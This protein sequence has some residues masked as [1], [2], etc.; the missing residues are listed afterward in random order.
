MENICYTKVLWKFTTLSWSHKRKL[1]AM[2]CRNCLQKT[3]SL[4]TKTA[5][6]YD[7]RGVYFSE[8]SIQYYNIT[9]YRTIHTR[10]SKE[11]KIKDPN[12]VVI[13]D[14]SCIRD[15]GINSYA[16]L[17]HVCTYLYFHI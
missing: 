15:R 5:I 13:L 6:K 8:T 2:P 12:F 14:A 16:Q 11:A 7:F 17:F 10:H 1:T 4:T 9:L 3:N